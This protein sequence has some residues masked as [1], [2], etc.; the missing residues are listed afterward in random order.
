M[1]VRFPFLVCVIGLAYRYD[2]PV[3]SVSVS[4]SHQET[5]SSSTSCLL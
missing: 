2:T 4:C 1:N 5:R 3:T